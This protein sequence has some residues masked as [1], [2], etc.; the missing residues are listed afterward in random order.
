MEQ[1]LATINQSAWSEWAEYR[2][3]KKKPIS[4]AAR[5]KQWKLLALYGH[6]EQQRIID[7]SISND[8]QGLF[9]AR[10]QTKKTS[11]RAN[12]LEHDLT[13]RDWAR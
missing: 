12:T 8:Y 3:M 11:T 2:R 7:H 1:S 4:E 10:Q 5:R 6:E 13:S 9:P